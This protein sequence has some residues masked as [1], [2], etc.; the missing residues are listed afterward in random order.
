MPA[1]LELDRN[2]FLFPHVAA[3]T[4]ALRTAPDLSHYAVRQAAGQFRRELGHFLSVDPACLTL[5]HGA[6]DLL[7]RLLLLYRCNHDTVVIPSFSWGEYD[8]MAASLGYSIRHAPMVSQGTQGALAVDSGAVADI[9]LGEV[10]AHT[11]VL[12]AT[13]NNPTG[14]R[15]PDQ[16][17]EDLIARFPE[18]VFILD[19][20]YETLPGDLFARLAAHPRVHVLGSMSKF[21]G[22]P[23]LRLG[24]CTGALPEAFDMA[25]GHGAWTLDV[26]RAALQSAPY[27]ADVH[28]AMLGAARHLA[29]IPLAHLVVHTSV[30]PFVL[31][32]AGGNTGM[33]DWG[34]VRAHCERASGVRP[35]LF[36]HGGRL[37]MRFGLGPDPVVRG[38]RT[39]LAEWDAVASQWTCCSGLE[40]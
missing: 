24:F 2:E 25:L 33:P 40:R 6:E 29:E 12:L 18:C 10:P 11:I 19:G 20:V 13:T 16:A 3:V 23:G 4:A 32:D 39:Y 8:R 9:L 21:F 7:L 30:A 38:V 26:A 27:Y 5:G 35:K 15:L 17:L 1:L 36:V 28:H 22:L 14:S 34:D 37:W 31:V